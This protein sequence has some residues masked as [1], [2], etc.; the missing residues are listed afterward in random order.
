MKDI[1]ETADAPAAIGPYSQA[2]TF[3]N[4]VITSGQI[5]LTPAGELVAGG[6]TEQTE[7]AEQAEQAPGDAAGI[8]EPSTRQPVTT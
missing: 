4:L 5:P 8:E 6:V 7:Q 1:V 3:G 2:V